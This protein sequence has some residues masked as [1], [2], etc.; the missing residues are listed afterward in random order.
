MLIETNS[1]RQMRFVSQMQNKGEWEI[2]IRNT[3]MLER[4]TLVDIKAP[5]GLTFE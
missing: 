5:G 2:Q 4:S 1:V 3:Q